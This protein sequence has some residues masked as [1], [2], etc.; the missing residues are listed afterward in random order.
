MAAG[1]RNNINKMCLNEKFKLFTS[2]VHE[3]WK[4]LGDVKY[5]SLLKIGCATAG[6]S[7]G[8]R[9]ASF[10]QLLMSQVS[11]ILIS[12]HIYHNLVDNEYCNQITEG[13][14]VLGPVYFSWVMILY[15]EASPGETRSI[16]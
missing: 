6:T 8:E 10:R 1:A 11:D 14:A 16:L 13:V 9:L 15:D 12:D 5:H 3:T 2:P 4:A 7:I